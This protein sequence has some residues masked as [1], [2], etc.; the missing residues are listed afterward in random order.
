M[1]EPSGDV[2]WHKYECGYTVDAP[3]F[4]YT[5]AMQAQ[6]FGAAQTSVQWQVCQLSEIVG[7]GDVAVAES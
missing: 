4:T 5:T 1:G 2:V 7:R 3:Q 6:D